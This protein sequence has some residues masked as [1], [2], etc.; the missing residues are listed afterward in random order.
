MRY[1]FGNSI[2]ITEEYTTFTDMLL[3]LHDSLNRKK[4]I[5]LSFPTAF[6]S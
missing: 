3:L 1:F 4:A 6:K 2:K 5:K